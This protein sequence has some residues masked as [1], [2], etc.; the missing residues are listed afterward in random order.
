MEGIS[1]PHGRL[2]TLAA[3][4]KTSLQFN[5]CV[6]K[7]TT[8]NGL[9]GAADAKYHYRRRLKITNKLPSESRY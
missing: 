4:F 5:E 6:N 8:R 7:L 1:L 2:K 9:T 3:L